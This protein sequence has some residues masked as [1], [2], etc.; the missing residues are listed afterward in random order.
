MSNSVDP[1]EKAHMSSLSWIYDVCK[2]LL[3]SPVVVKVKESLCRSILPVT[4][5][6]Y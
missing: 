1:D 2:I 5:K 6:I 4:L 3:L